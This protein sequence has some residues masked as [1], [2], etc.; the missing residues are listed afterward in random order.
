MVKDLAVIIDYGSGNLHSAAKAAQEAGTHEVIISDKAED[1]ARAGH[2]IL[3]GQGAFGDCMDGLQRSG[4]LDAL[5]DAVMQ[6][7]VPFLGI[8]V[9][10]QLL[11]DRGTEHGAHTG[12]GWLG[13]SVDAIAPA[14]KALKIPHM[15]WNSVSFAKDHPVLGG[16]SEGAHFYFVHSYHMVLAGDADLLMACDYGG[17][18][19][20]AVA[21]S[22]IIGTQ[23]HPEKSGADGLRLIANF[24]NWDGRV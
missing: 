18:I 15:G 19:T 7:G 2:L 24:L 11:A 8:C 9:G 6:R 20:A 13:G 12:L 16:L 17:P 14:D 10:M 5:E 21:K 22:N 3:P 1:I 4:L 23:F